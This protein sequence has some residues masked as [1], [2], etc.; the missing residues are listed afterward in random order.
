MA[1]NH[2]CRV[3]NTAIILLPFITSSGAS[4][5]AFPAKFG[6]GPDNNQEILISTINSAKKQL[7]INIYQF[8]NPIISRAIIDQ[9]KNGVTVKLL[10]E[11]EPLGQISPGGRKTIHDIRIA[12]N[13]VYNYEN[14]IFLMTSNGTGDRRFRFNHA[15][16]IVVDYDGVFI[17]SENF[18]MTGHTIPGDVGNR[19][20]VGFINNPDLSTELADIFFYD[21]DTSYGDV[22]EI[23][24]NG[25]VFGETK[26]DSGIERPSRIRTIPA[27]PSGSGVV[28]EVKLLKSPD[29][30]ENLLNVIRLSTNHLEIE[31]MSLPSI[32]REPAPSENQMQNP[33]LT[34]LLNAARRGVKI[35]VLLN[36]DR[37]FTEKA[38]G[39]T[40]GKP[41]FVDSDSKKPNEI[42][43]EVIENAALCEN[44]PIEARIVDTKAVEI[45]YI[46]NK[47]IIV[48]GLY[49]LVSSINGTRNSVMNN[50]E[51]AMLLESPDASSYYGN[52]FEF[53]WI[54][55]PD[56]P[57]TNT[58][59]QPPKPNLAFYLGDFFR[60]GF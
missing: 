1:Y 21:S 7:L 58:I 48:D 40:S 34:E 42:T 8:D 13:N 28:T 12:M 51:I 38:N 31:Q 45:T 6:L 52:A 49:T 19:G 14:R 10:I 56:F 29:E 46:H 37:V 55:S 47:G 36:D 60:F 27:I 25:K 2:V 43:A 11:G 32:W 3:L 23:R 20:W 54:S 50:R 9:I 44:L 22:I 59:C 24:R 4:K 18:S 15:K 41:N 5:A 35:R 16:Y 26:P 30:L 39:H 57:V 17:S 33:I 53:D